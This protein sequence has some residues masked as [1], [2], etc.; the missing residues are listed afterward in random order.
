MKLVLS[1]EYVTSSF[2]MPVG[3]R[4]M[5]G[6]VVRIM[7]SGQCSITTTSASTMGMATTPASGRLRSCKTMCKGGC[8]AW[9]PC[10]T[11]PAITA[12]GSTTL[13]TRDWKEVRTF[14]SI[15]RLLKRPTRLHLNCCKTSIN[16][17]TR[18][19]S[20]MARTTRRMTRRMTSLTIK[21]M[22][23][24]MIKL[25]TPLQALSSVIGTMITAKE[26]LWTTANWLL[27]TMTSSRVSTVQLTS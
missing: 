21:L 2:V 9:R 1:A 18:S 26:T 10:V 17:T 7:S 25:T 20:Q 4:C 3:I 13:P 12:T 22:I 14:T 23:N 6:D 5:R 11:L 8:F 24:L 15:E 16:T 19:K 27:M